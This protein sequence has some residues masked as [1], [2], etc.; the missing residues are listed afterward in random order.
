[1]ATDPAAPASANAPNGP[2]LAGAPGVAGPGGRRERGRG[3]GHYPPRRKVC[4]FCVEKIDNIDYKDVTRLRRYI[5]DRGKI[6]PRRKTGTCAKHQRRLSRALKRARQAALL[7]IAAKHL[8]SFGGWFQ[9]PPFLPTPAAP[10]PVQAPAPASPVEA[11]PAATAP[12]PEGED[13][14]GPVSGS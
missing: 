12:T 7:P 11:A 9:P 3:R 13:A 1:L 8:F 4:Q 10:P 2:A 14:R 6:E 5:S